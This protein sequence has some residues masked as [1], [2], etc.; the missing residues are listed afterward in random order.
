MSCERKPAVQFP[1]ACARQVHRLT[2]TPYSPIDVLT[3]SGRR[4]SDASAGFY[5]RK[6][7]VLTQ[8]RDR[9][10]GDNDGESGSE[11]TGHRLLRV[12]SHLKALASQSA[13][14]CTYLFGTETK[15]VPLISDSPSPSGVRLATMHTG[16]SVRRIA[17]SAR[18]NRSCR[19]APP[20]GTPASRRDQIECFEPVIRPWHVR[21]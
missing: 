17:M 13:L 11:M 9:R 7:K 1:D 5:G 14:C 21:P 8:S 19:L 15:A 16:G 20:H 4:S 6:I 2:A 3:N 18:T 12:A 10:S